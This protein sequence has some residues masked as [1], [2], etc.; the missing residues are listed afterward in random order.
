MRYWLIMGLCLLAPC[1]AHAWTDG[2]IADAIWRAEGCAAGTCEYYY[3]IRSVNYKTGKGGAADR[4]EARRICI[5][6][7][8][9]QRVRW[10]KGGKVGEYLVSLW[11][12]YCPVGV[13][14][15]PKGLNCN[16]LKNVRW[17]LN[18]R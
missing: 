2:E 7:I 9:N 18:N 4:A 6:T 13:A 3:G 16:W 15:D 1:T 14:N 11:K 12:R 10:A 17:A 8:R 5:N